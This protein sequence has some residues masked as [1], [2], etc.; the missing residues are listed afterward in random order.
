MVRKLTLFENDD[1]RVS[2]FIHI[3]IVTIPCLLGSG[4]SLIVKNRVN[5]CNTQIE[6]GKKIYVKIYATLFLLL[7]KHQIDTLKNLNSKLLKLE[8]TVKPILFFIQYMIVHACR[9]VQIH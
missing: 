1:G 9:L 3:D 5:Q 4:R 7:Y 6:N 2:D 8:Y